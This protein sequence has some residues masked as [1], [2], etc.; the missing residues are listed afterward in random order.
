MPYGLYISAEG[1]AAQA[2]RLDVIANNL[3]NVDTAGFKQD[4]PTFQARFAEAIQEGL[5][6]P[7]DRSINDVGGGVKLIDVTTDHSEGE[8]KHTG[9]DLDVAINGK[10]FFQI[11]GDDGK[12]YLTRAGNF[13]L[14][15]LGVLV[16][17]NGQRPVLDQSGSQI[18]LDASLPFAIS[19]DGFITQSGSVFALGLSQP[20]S[21]DN[22]VKV[23]NNLYEPLGKVQPVRLEERN[24]RQ[25][26]L[27]ASGANPVRQMM[28]MIET[29][30]AFEAN[31]RMVQSQDT[32]I[33]TLIGRVLRA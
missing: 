27:E 29:T 21:L 2:Q 6:R 22:L 4:V 30:R 19:Q 5:A 26:Y 3:A 25:G 16:S 7:H 1:A 9:Q 23:G 13:M 11:R 12:Q 17:Q 31:T 18:Q 20:D 32:M 33:G 15:T 14:N 28:A 8:L 24:I 10:G